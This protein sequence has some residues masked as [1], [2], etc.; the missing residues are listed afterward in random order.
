[1]ERG[2]ERKGGYRTWPWSTTG[3]H[4]WKKEWQARRRE[5]NNVAGHPE[6]KEEKGARG[7]IRNERERE[8]YGGV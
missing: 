8:G 5:K 3:V 2:I 4:R 7:M 1:M 6:N